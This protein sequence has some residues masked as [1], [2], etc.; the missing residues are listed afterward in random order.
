MGRR[1]DPQ[2]CHV[3]TE[4]LDLGLGEDHL[5][6]D[7]QAV[8]GEEHVLGATQ[9]DALG[10]EVAGVGGVLTGVGVRAHAQAPS[11]VGPAEQGREAG[12]RGRP[13]DGEL[14]DVGHARR[15]VDALVADV[16]GSPPPATTTIVPIALIEREST[17]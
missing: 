4:A 14:S 15:A 3:P 2:R 16:E 8:G 10:A 6:H 11:V 12:R 9:A 7:R 13:L 5:A 1:H 17:R